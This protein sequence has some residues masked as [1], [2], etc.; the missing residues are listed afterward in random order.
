MTQGDQIFCSAYYHLLKKLIETG[1]L[2]KTTLQQEQ[3][4]FHLGESHC[5]SYAHH[6]I[7]IRGIDCNV[8]PRITL[9]AK[10]YHFSVKRENAFKAITMA[11]F[12]SLPDG[13]NVFI[14][15]GEIDCRQNEGF[16][17]AAAKQKKPIEKLVTD[18]VSGYVSWFFEQNQ[19][20]EHS[21]FFLNVPAP[22]FQKKFSNDSNKEMAKVV[23]LFND[24]L[25]KQLLIYNFNIIDLYRFTVGNNG[26]SNGL[27]HIDKRHLSSDALPEIEKQ[28]ATLV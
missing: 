17:Y 19:S 5:L 23:K 4:V 2:K 15:F 9:G 3:T 16:V 6:K 27:F 13:S 12:D 1:V 24:E 11:N 18:T 25:A 14:S 10:A 8:K 28:I 7:K 21:L 22:T 20:R 26:F